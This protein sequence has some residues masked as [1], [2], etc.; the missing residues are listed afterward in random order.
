MLSPLTTQADAVVSCHSYTV[1]HFLGCMGNQ[2]GRHCLW[3]RS[4]HLPMR[5]EEFLAQNRQAE[6]LG[7][8]PPH[9]YIQI[10]IKAYRKFPA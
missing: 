4:Q 5:E 9:K 7:A 8:E 2:K 1:Q 6:M 10:T 3:V